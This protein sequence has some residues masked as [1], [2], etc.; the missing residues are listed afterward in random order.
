MADKKHILIAILDNTIG[1]Q[2][3]SL[4]YKH[5]YCFRCSIKHYKSK[6]NSETLPYNC[7]GKHNVSI[8][9]KE[10]PK[11]KFSLRDESFD[12]ILGY[13][14]YLFKGHISGHTLPDN[15]KKL[16]IEQWEKKLEGKYDG[17]KK[18]PLYLEQGGIKK[19]D[20]EIPI[21]NIDRT[22][23]PYL[24][25]KEYKNADFFGSLY[26]LFYHIEVSMRNFLR[27]RLNKLYN[28]KTEWEK[29]IKDTGNFN[30]AF[31][32][33]KDIGLQKNYPKRGDD[34]LNYCNWKDYMNVF[35]INSNI[36]NKSDEL[37]ELKATFRVM[38][39]IRNAIA[40]N[41]ETITSDDIQA[42]K[43]FVKTY[44]RIMG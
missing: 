21:E 4:R 14:N 2:Y 29:A 28:S 13:L 7:K 37:D 9:C 11:V 25:N 40:H 5:C 23:I 38:Y 16:I 24:N 42:M 17:R 36:W 20:F 32:L 34:I 10:T 33:R 18:E 27:S 39:K 30:H 1:K 6:I 35:D 41:A 19:I 12:D 31:A 15:I 26:F 3:Q 22:Q 8:R 44:I 43:V